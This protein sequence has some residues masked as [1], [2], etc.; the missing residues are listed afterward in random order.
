[1]SAY[2]PKRTLHIES[3]NLISCYRGE[4]FRLTDDG[5]RPPF[6]LD[7][8]GFSRAANRRPIK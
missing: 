4:R 5:Y 7:F 3:H 1:M 8:T 2:D 6:A